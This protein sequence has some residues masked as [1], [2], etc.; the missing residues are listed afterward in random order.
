MFGREGGA[1]RRRAAALCGWTILEVRADVAVLP[2]R[3]AFPHPCVVLLHQ[4][5]GK[6]SLQEEGVTVGSTTS[7]PGETGKLNS[8]TRKSNP[9]CSTI[10]TRPSVHGCKFPRSTETICVLKQPWEWIS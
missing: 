5:S 3:D 4:M 8:K 10:H 7:A 1:W 6:G 9:S 2:E